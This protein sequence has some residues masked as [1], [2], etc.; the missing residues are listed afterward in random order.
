MFQPI[1]INPK[2]N[3][4]YQVY[5]ILYVLFLWSFKFM[6]FYVWYFLFLL[7][8]WVKMW[9][10][11]CVEPLNIWISVLKP[12]RLNKHLEFTRDVK[13]VYFF[14]FFSFVDNIIHLINKLLLLLLFVRLKVKIIRIFYCAILLH[15]T[16]YVESLS[17]SNRM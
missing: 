11:E 14:S 17:T 5:E 8:P 15:M 4:L 10:N 6:K 2:D 7:V 13:W 12:C 3:T 16:R 9:Q 1:C